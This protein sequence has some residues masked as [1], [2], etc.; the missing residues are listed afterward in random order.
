[1]EELYNGAEKSFNMQKK[2]ICKKCRGTGSKDGQLKV[3]K[4]CNGQGARMQ[5]VNMGIGTISNH[6]DR[7]H[8]VN[9][10]SLR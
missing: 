2:V 3:C 9:A 5:N 6:N 10:S 1:M 7:I 4:A 8:G